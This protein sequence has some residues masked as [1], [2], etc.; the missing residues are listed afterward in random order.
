[1]KKIMLL[2]IIILLNSN[3]NANEIKIK[4]DTLFLEDIVGAKIKEP[5]ITNLNFGERTFVPKERIRSILYRLNL[6]DKFKEY[7]KDYTVVREGTLLTEKELKKSFIEK[8]GK[9]YPNFDFEVER[10]SYNNNIFYQDKDNIS[11]DIPS[12]PFGSTYIDVDNGYKKYSLYTYLKVYKDAYVAKKDIRRGSTLKGNVIREK[13]D[14]T[15]KYDDLVNDI[16]GLIARTTIREGKIITDVYVEKKPALKRGAS[17]KIR[18]KGDYVLVESKGVLREDA[19]VGKYVRVK[20]V[21]SNKV[22]TGKYIG[23]SIVSV[24]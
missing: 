24:N 22:L 16:D 23:D 21:R 1:M 19:F 4:G 12:Q 3:L 6:L 15:N 20:N 14:V 5:I 9:I 7:V 10:I 17:V 2:L 11:F 18:Y 13:V 8:L